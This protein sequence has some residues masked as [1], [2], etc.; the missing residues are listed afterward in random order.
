MV[1]L[2]LSRT[3]AEAV[4][5][6]PPP[7]A[8]SEEAAPSSD[9]E[10]VFRAVSDPTRRAILELLRDEERTAG[11]LAAPFEMSRAAISQHLRVLKEA[12]LVTV[13]SEGR[14]R[15]YRLNPLPLHVLFDWSALFEDFWRDRLRGLRTHLDGAI[16]E[17][18]TPTTSDTD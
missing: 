6:P 9:S 10:A 4:E 2:F 17:P 16:A 8:R 12:E 13:R 7:V 1:A 11:D 15:I 3:S 5:A 18:A 14:A